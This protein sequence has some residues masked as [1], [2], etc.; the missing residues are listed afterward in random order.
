M[1]TVQNPAEGVQEAAATPKKKRRG[2]SNETSGTSNLKF[3]EKDA[4]PSGLFVGRIDSVKCGWAHIGEESS[5]MGDFAGHAIPRFEIHFTSIHSNTAERRHVTLTINPVQSTVETYENGEKSWMVNRVFNYI[6]HILDVLY[7]NGRSLTE[8]EEDALALSYNDCDDEGN[9]LPVEV[10]DVI[11][12]WQSVFESAA[13]MLNGTFATKDKEATGKPCYKTDKG[14]ARFYMKLLRFI[15]T[16]RG[17]NAK[18]AAVGNNGDLA[19][20]SFVGEGVIEKMTAVD[21]LPKILRLNP[22]TESI[23]PQK[24]EEKKA[25]AMPG[26]IPGGMPG[27][28][29]GMPGFGENTNDAAFAAGGDMPF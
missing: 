27:I 26:G 17:A 18:W 5:G 28:P 25:P 22:L 2:I 23:V 24:T 21:A 13:A 9:Y 20:P 10:D 4:I 14:D 16:G 11:K 7:L 15:K 12:G 19:F 6:K 29:G 8:E 1:K 3:H